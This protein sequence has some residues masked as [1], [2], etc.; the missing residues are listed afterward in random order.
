[1]D[2]DPPEP[3][4]TAPRALALDLA[5][6]DP[7]RATGRAYAADPILLRL[8]APQRASAPASQRQAPLH[9]SPTTPKRAGT[10]PP[11]AT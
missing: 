1:M 5:L 3:A 10:P 9:A 7:T 2:G 6:R 4:R 8:R 11:L